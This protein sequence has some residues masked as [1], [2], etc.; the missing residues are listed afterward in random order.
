MTVGQA[1]REL[2]KRLDIPADAASVVDGFV[3]EAT[4]VLAAGQTLVFVR[5]AGEMG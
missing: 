4:A 1:R 5:R 2:A 3:A